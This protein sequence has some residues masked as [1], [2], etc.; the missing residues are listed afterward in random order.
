MMKKIISIVGLSVSL[1]MVICGI[2]ALSGGMG[3]DTRLAACSPSPYDSG[4]ATFGSDFYTYVSNN[5]QEAA[6]AARIAGDNV[7]ALADLLKNAFGW[8]MICIGFISM[9][10]FAMVL[11][12]DKFK[13]PPMPVAPMPMGDI[14]MVMPT[15]FPPAPG[16]NNIVCA[17]CGAERASGDFCR[18][19]GSAATM[20][21]PM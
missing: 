1:I 6:A 15:P 3:G 4:Y 10:A 7:D 18:E 14:P 17:N 19:C 8:A 21:K 2:V 16:I 9:C 5:A 13:N 11:F 20:A 12:G